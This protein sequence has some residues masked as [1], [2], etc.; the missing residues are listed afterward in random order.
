LAWTW[1]IREPNSRTTLSM[2]IICQTR[3]D[4]SRL[5][6][7]TSSSNQPNTSRQVAGA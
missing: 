1:W 5:S 3:C 4:G 7:R 2:S 6:P